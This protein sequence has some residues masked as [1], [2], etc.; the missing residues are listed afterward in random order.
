MYL[1]GVKRGLFWTAAFL[2]LTA[3]Y[4]LSTLGPSQF[5][6][7]PQQ[8]AACRIDPYCSAGQVGSLRFLLASA[9]TRAYLEPI[10][11]LFTQARYQPDYRMPG[12]GILYGVLRLFTGNRKIAIWGLFLVTIALWGIAVGMWIAQLEKK[13]LPRKILWLLCG[14]IA[15]SPF[16][17]YTRVLI[18]DILAAA[19]GLLSLRALRERKYFWAGLGLTWSFF[20]RPVLGIWLP[21]AGIVLLSPLRQGKWRPV[22]LF[23]LPFLLA[24][25]AWIARNVLQYGDVRPLHGTNTLLDPGMY[26]DI[27][28]EVRKLLQIVGRD[29]NMTWNDPTHPYALLLCQGDTL[30]PLSVWKR[31]FVSLEKSPSCPPETLYAIGAGLCRLI[32][33]PTY[34]IARGRTDSPAPTPAD[35]ALEQE[36][37]RRLHTCTE[38]AKAHLGVMRPL[39]ALVY[40]LWDIRF[41]PAA[42][43][44]TSFFRKLYFTIFYLLLWGVGFLALRGLWRGEGETRLMVAFAWLPLLAYLALGVVERRY[45]DLQW[46]FLLFAAALAWRKRQ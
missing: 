34:G 37:S 30:Q 43:R 15:F 35:C 20:M 13:G 38:A 6:R 39:H 31:A 10:D 8:Q 5:L 45:I 9:D 25:G 4:W 46:P 19:V 42:G 21:A 7:T 27:T 22:F 33:S 28:W 26:H 44:P 12:Y 29:A 36:L 3:V 14:L 23:S 2:L 24:E 32:T 40:R 1:R 41:V 18:P 17:Y 16:S 11:R